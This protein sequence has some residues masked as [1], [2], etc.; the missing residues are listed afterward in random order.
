MHIGLWGCGDGYRDDRRRV[1]EIVVRP[2]LRARHKRVHGPLTSDQIAGALRKC[3]DSAYDLYQSGKLL[4]H[5]GPKTTASALIVLAL[6]E[7]GKIGWLYLALMFPR[8]DDEAWGYFWDGYYS[9][10]L[11]SEVAHEMNIGRNNLLPATARFLRHDVFSFSST[12]QVLDR[13]KQAVLY[14]DYDSKRQEFRGPRDYPIDNEGLVE[15]VENLVIYTAQNEKARVFDAQ[16][17]AEF[18]VLNLLAGSDERL[19]AELLTVFYDAVLGTMPELAGP[20][21]VAHAEAAARAACA[22]EVGQVI[23]RWRRLGAALKSN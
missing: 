14:S 16:V 21:D 10:R 12:S 7:Y 1:R 8:A 9:H 20:P 2:G 4:N 6:E 3:S 11:K 19:R 23:A 22:E 17:V 15:V 18:Q 5:A 13:E